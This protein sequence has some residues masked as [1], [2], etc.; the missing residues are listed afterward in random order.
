M[1]KSDLICSSTLLHRRYEH[2]MYVFENAKFKS[3]NLTVTNSN[4]T[5]SSTDLI[6]DY[7]T[8]ST[9]GHYWIWL[10]EDVLAFTIR[11][12]KSDT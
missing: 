3:Q 1:P 4:V 6:V 2:L 8:K 10:K 7:C 9:N 12:S 11:S 5:E